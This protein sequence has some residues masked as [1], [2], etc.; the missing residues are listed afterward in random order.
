MLTKEEITNR[1]Q[2]RVATVVAQNTGLCAQTI[3][4]LKSG[5]SSYEISYG[6]IALLS[7]YLENTNR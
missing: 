1:L 6:T 7:D 2:D 5:K 4:K 3:R